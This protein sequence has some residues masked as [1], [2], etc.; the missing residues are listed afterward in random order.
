MKPKIVKWCGFWMCSCP[1]V[2]GIGSTPRAA[3]TNWYQWRCV[4]GD[5]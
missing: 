5:L 3:Y 1:T 4:R 2:T